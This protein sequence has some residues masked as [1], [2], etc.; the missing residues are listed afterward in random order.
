MLRSSLV[1]YSVEDLRF[2]SFEGENPYNY[3]RCSYGDNSDKLN[4]INELL[5]EKFEFIGDVIPLNK[6][7][8]LNSCCMC[9]EIER[10]DNEIDRDTNYNTNTLHFLNEKL[11]NPIDRV[12]MGVELEKDNNDYSINFKMY[13]SYHY[14]EQLGNKDSYLNYILNKYYPKTFE[15]T[16][17]LRKLNYMVCSKWRSEREKKFNS[18]HIHHQFNDLNLHLVYRFFSDNEIEK[19]IGFIDYD[20]NLNEFLLK[21]LRKRL[22]NNIRMTKDLTLSTEILTSIDLYKIKVRK[23]EE[24]FLMCK[25]NPK[26]KY[27]K[28]FINGLYEDNFN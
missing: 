3:K 25:Y 8:Y 11:N 24:F 22:R 9:E 5:D 14:V 16:N 13:C 20:P 6:R 21:S 7:K 12:F 1:I 2:N 10:Y 28:N 17:H 18:I 4:A 15:D 26:Y 23:I 27:C 19:Y